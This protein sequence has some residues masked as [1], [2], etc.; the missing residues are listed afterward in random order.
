MHTSSHT[1][2]LFEVGRGI[3]APIRVDTTKKPGSWRRK[4]KSGDRWSGR[5]RLVYQES[6]L[7]RS[8]WSFTIEHTNYYADAGKGHSPIST[9]KCDVKGRM[10]W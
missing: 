5:H 2:L 4:T 3:P 6:D 10:I 1:V 7:L 9:K 8:G